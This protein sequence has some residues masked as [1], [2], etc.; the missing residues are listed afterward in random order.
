MLKKNEDAPPPDLLEIHACPSRM[1]MEMLADKWKLM[2][3]H[4]LRSQPVMRNGELMRSIAGI[5]Q[6]MLTQ[7]LRALER[8]GLVLRKDFQ[9]VPPR[10]EY[11]LTCLGQSLG[12]P[13]A[14]ISEW[15]Q[16][17]MSHVLDARDQFD[18]RES[19]LSD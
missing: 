10:V 14:L 9:E 13:I 8:D 1:V 17:N 12:E 19:V 5:S 6:K 18:Q 15:G 2:V 4:S 11:S 16:T 3:F 7:T